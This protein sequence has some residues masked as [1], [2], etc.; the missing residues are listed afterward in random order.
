MNLATIEPA[1]RAL[2]ATLTGVEPACC[3]FENEPRPRSNGALVLLSWVSRA[4]VGI[5]E[6]EYVYAANADPLLEMTP[7][8]HGPREASLQ[9]AVEVIADQRSGFSAA[10]RIEA[11]RTRFRWP[12]AL[13]ALSAAGLAL[14]TI[15]PA[16]TADYQADGRMVSRSLFEVRLN[17]TSSEGDAAGRTSYIV[18]ADVSGTVNRPDG[19]PVPDTLQ[20]TTG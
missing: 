14:A 2:A 17:A 12:S 8:V 20:P 6:T 18:T 9:F 4:P 5:D 16:T 11:A 3:V 7:T 19:T 15:G 1:L 13:A 10:A